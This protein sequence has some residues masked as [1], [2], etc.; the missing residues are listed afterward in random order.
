MLATGLVSWPLAD[1]VSCLSVSADGRP[2]RIDRKIY[3]PPPDRESR[4]E[5]L[6]IAL[7]GV[8]VEDKLDVEHLAR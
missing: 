4:V 8:P 3:V 6:G 5:I 1:G 2:G 7:R